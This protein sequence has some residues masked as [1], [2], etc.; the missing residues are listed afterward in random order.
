MSYAHVLC[1]SSVLHQRFAPEENRSDNLFQH[2]TKWKSDDSSWDERTV[3]HYLWLCGFFLKVE[4]RGS[5]Q[6]SITIPA[7][8]PRLLLKWQW[9][10]DIRCGCFNWKKQTKKTRQKYNNDTMRWDQLIFPGTSF[11]S[12]LLYFLKS[13]FWLQT[14][15]RSDEE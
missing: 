13:F 8:L 4:L 2:L 1:L 14:W 11:S 6:S 3:K 9:C 7:Q 15:C 12:R 5:S 10:T